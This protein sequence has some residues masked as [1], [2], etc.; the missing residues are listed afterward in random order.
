LLG[1]FEFL[2]FFFLLADIEHRDPLSA[3]R[4]WILVVSWKMPVATG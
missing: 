4:A 3:T 1:F 2:F